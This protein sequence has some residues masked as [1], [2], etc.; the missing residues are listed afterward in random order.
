MKF[1]QSL[2]SIEWRDINRFKESMFLTILISAALWIIFSLHLKRNPHTLSRKMKVNSVSESLLYIQQCNN[3]QSKNISIRLLQNHLCWSLKYPHFHYCLHHHFLQTQ[4]HCLHHMSH[5]C[6]YYQIHFLQNPVVNT[7]PPLWSNIK[8]SWR[9]SH[10]RLKILSFVEP[11]TVMIHLVLFAG[12]WYVRS[13]AFQ[14]LALLSGHVLSQLS[15]Q[16]FQEFVEILF[17]KCTF[18]V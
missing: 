6:Y 1:K 2:E 8:T 9:L 14:E 17:G 15:F 5:Y 3:L 10:W 12:S 4:H 18:V 11:V 7:N 13:K 16:S